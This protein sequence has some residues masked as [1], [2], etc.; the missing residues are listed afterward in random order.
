MDISHCVYILG[1]VL[2]Y[3]W[4]VEWNKL[5]DNPP[6]HIRTCPHDHL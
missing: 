2:Q 4:R 3:E 5:I 1:V 6:A